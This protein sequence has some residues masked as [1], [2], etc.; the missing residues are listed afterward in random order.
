MLS[1]TSHLDVQACEKPTTA[2]RAQKVNRILKWGV[3]SVKPVDRKEA[4]YAAIG[5]GDPSVRIVNSV[6]VTLDFLGEL[7]VNDAHDLAN[8]L[9][10]HQVIDI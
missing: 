1:G 5:G 10:F 2:P 4:P 7:L 3:V 8:V 9:H 6:G